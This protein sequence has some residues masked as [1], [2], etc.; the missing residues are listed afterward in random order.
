MEKTLPDG[1]KKRIRRRI[2][3]IKV[4]KKPKEIVNEDPL[5][6]EE[7]EIDEANPDD[8]QFDPNVKSLLYK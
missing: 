4:V 6:C 5:E 2:I 8:E 7:I 3:V 1:S